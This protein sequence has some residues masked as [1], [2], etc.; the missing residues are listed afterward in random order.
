MYGWMIDR[1]CGPPNTPET[2]CGSVAD[3]GLRANNDTM[4]ISPA[5]AETTSSG[6][7]IYGARSLEWYKSQFPLVARTC[8]SQLIVGAY[9]DYTEMNAWSPAV[10]PRCRTG[11]EKDPYLFWN[12]TLEG[13]AA[14]RAACGST[15]AFDRRGSAESLLTSHRPGGPLPL[16][17]P[18]PVSNDTRFFRVV[19]DANGVSW[20]RRDTQPGSPVNDTHF[21]SA[22][23]T[24]IHLG[25]SVCAANGTRPFDDAVRAKFG[26]ERF[27]DGFINETLV[28]MARMGF[29][30]AGAWSYNFESVFNG[31]NARP[32][33]AP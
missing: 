5:Y 2:P 33:V 24:C 32:C 11:E 30:T 20:F 10:C 7:H 29:N 8:P 18:V 31:T 14:V 27:V 17:P 13:L 15:T 26:D 25:Q 3:V 1:T 21:I 23:I 16:P 19:E 22:G 6:D 12:A 9:N 4:Y 28:R